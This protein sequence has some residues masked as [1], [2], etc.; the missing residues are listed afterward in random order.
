VNLRTTAALGISTLL[1]DL[2]GA[3][4]WSAGPLVGVSFLGVEWK[5]APGYFLVVDPTYLVF[6]MPHLTGVP[7]GYY[8]YRF[9]VG[10]EFGG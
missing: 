1:I 6:A 5:I 2:P 10:I 9:Q 3:E 7:L 4:K 8:Q